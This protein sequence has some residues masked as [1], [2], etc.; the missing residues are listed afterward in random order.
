[1]KI[2]MKILQHIYTSPSSGNLQVH[3]VQL[4]IERNYMF[5]V[6]QDNPSKYSLYSLLLNH[7]HVHHPL[8]EH[9]DQMPIIIIT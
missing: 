2:F 3:E 4:P 5:Q 6:R 1:M 7:D 8:R 9:E